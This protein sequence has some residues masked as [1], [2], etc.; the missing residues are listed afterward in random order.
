MALCKH[1]NLRSF[2][3][4]NGDV[5]SMCPEPDCTY[6]VGH[7]SK[8]YTKSAGRLK[9]VEPVEP[10]QEI[11]S[12]TGEEEFVEPETVELQPLSFAALEQDEDDKPQTALMATDLEEAAER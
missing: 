4:K 8:M 1:P 6:G 2:T 7:E 11:I 10:E 3:F 9:E 5:M 12:D